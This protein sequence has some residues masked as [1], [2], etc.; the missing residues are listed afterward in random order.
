MVLADGFSAKLISYLLTDAAP[1]LAESF[2][3]DFSFIHSQSYFFFCNLD[4]SLV[5]DRQNIYDSNLLELSPNIIHYF[6][7]LFG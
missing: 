6:L 2:R 1:F 3:D 7:L 4:I 5:S